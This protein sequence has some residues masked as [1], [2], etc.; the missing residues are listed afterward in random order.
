MPI[1][2]TAP[3]IATANTAC[4]TVVVGAGPSVLPAPS[5]TRI[6]LQTA[7]RMEILKLAGKFGPKWSVLAKKIR[8]TVKHHWINKGKG[9]K[10]WNMIF[11]NE[12]KNADNFSF[13]FSLF[14][15][16]LK[17]PRQELDKSNCTKRRVNLVQVVLDNICNLRINKKCF[18]LKF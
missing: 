1:P 13:Y 5:A 12:D 18:N 17:F 4:V 10:A 2:L 7:T 6:A 9:K 3:I 15:F 8:K 14:T 11:G 16:G